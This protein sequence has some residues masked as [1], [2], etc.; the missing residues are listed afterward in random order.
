MRTVYRARLD[1]IDRALVETGAEV[2]SLIRNATCALLDLDL[3]QA[4][5][6]I[7][8][9]AQVGTRIAEIEDQALDLVAR[10]QP[11]AQDARSLVSTLRILMSLQ[12][13]GD[14]AAHVAKA[15][16]IRYPEPVVPAELRGVVQDMGDVADAMTLRAGHAVAQHDITAAV[17]LDHM[18]LE[19]D[20]LH[21]ELLAIVLSEAWDHGVRTAVDTTLVSRYYERYADHAAAIGQC[22]RYAVTGL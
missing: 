9:N 22:V 11:V 16:R 2:R 5:S 19:M 21:R 10:Q 20:R 14:L 4:E 8:R 1:A 6:I 12:R 15:M 7:S 18:D 17:E 13:M 3:R